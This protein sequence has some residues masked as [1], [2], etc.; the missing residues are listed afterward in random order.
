[1]SNEI[2]KEYKITDLN[3][4]KFR[5]PL[6]Q[7]AYTW[8]EDEVEQL[9]NDLKLSKEKKEKEETDYFIGNIVV[10]DKNGILN[11][12]DGQQRLTTIF[13]ISK[14]INENYF[15]LDYEIRENDKLFLNDFKR[16]N[17]KKKREEYNAHIQFE[18]NIDKILQFEEEY[19]DCLK[20]LL[21]ICKIT[22]TILPQDVDIV[23]YFEVMNNRGKQLEKHQILKAKFLEILKDEKEIDWA[24]IWDYCSNMNV[25]VEDSIYYGDLKK[26]EKDIEKVRKNFRD[27]IEKNEIPENFKGEV[28]DDKLS[29]SD[30]IDDN[31][32]MG[33]KE[34]EEFYIRKEYGS[35]VKF[36]I[37]L[38][39]ILKIFLAKDNKSKQMKIND[40]Y[41]IEYYTKEDGNLIFDKD[42]TKEFLKFLLRM[43]LLYDYFIFKRDEEGNPLLLED[44]NLYEVKNCNKKNLL[45]LQLLFN[46]TSPQ[47]FAQ[48]WISPIL[49]W[50][51]KNIQNEPF[52]EN[53]EQLLENFDKELAIV[54]LNGKEIIS[55]INE[56]IYNSVEVTE[57]IDN[58]IEKKLQKI[59][60][61]GTSTPHYWFYKLDYLLWKDYKWTQNF[62]NKF[63][64]NQFKYSNIKNTY[65]LSRLNSVEHIYPQ[66]KEQ[67][68][69]SDDCKIDYFGNLSLI[70]NH[71]NSALIDKEFENKRTRIQE[72]LNGNTIESLKMLLVYSKYK[73][74]NIEYCKEHH[75]EIIKILKESLQ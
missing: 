41:L 50:L 8:G 57:N 63:A 24:K 2:I 67:D 44:K 16:D 53:Y 22:L 14:I 34:K 26:D 66:S 23:K 70:S 52:C 35:I 27:F 30:I 48:H 60:N 59:L 13:L 45:M 42:K 40:R 28:C 3:D 10:E 29:I 18:R 5:I 72:Q 37:F 25:Y 68:F 1:M 21:E 38:I 64:E 4:K 61:Q 36:P 15:E 75:E 46:F 12:I 31:I 43:R 71:I 51:D 17:Y 73:E 6:Y 39:H 7:R 65:R 58:D 55:K 20:D 32:D 56:K 19:E 74:W 47:Y 9:L 69:K 11:I 54:R 49:A 33:I 62:A